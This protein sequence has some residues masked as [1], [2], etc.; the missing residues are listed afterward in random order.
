MA[1]EARLLKQLKKKNDKAIES[2]IELYTPYVS[3]VLYNIAGAILMREDIEEII[4]DVFISLWQNADKIDL[5]KGTIRSYIAAT[6]RNYALKRFMQRKEYT[7]I[8]DIE[9]PDEKSI[10]ED[11][12]MYDFLWKAVMELGEPDN[13]IFV[14]YYR[15]CEK[16]RDIAV[17]TGVNLSTVKT[18][19]SRGRQRLKKILSETEEVL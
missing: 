3:T 11:T 18:K 6:A 12:V 7:S 9:L 1:D 17:A 2:A 13:E 10:T 4:S 5:Q 15:Y 8:D 14:R 19:L 16:L